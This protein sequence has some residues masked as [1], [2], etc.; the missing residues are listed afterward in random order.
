M[1]LGEKFPTLHRIIFRVCLNVNIKTVR[2]FEESAK[3]ILQS[4]VISQKT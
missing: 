1:S 3:K 2:S 4:S